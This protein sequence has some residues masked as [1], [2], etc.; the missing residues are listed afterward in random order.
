MILFCVG[1]DM[2]ITTLA[3]CM[4][5]GEILRAFADDL[6]ILLR[7]LLRCRHIL[8]M[9]DILAVFTRCFL[10][11][12]KC[13]WVRAKSKKVPDEDMK[14]WLLWAKANF[15][16]SFRM[17]E[18]EN[19]LGF[20]IGVCVSSEHI[21]NPVMRGCLAT[22][23]KWKGS[24]SVREKLLIVM[25]YVLS[26]PA[27]L[28]QLADPPTGFDGTLKVACVCFIFGI[29][30]VK[31]DT[32]TC[33]R[34][35]G[36]GFSLPNLQARRLAMRAR[37][38]LSLPA[39]YPAYGV[40]TNSREVNYSSAWSIPVAKVFHSAYTEVTKRL[41][42]T[43]ATLKA[44][45]MAK[46]TTESARENVK[47]TIQR[48]LTARLTPT[49]VSYHRYLS[50]KF[51]KIGDG[52]AILAALLRDVDEWAKH[53]SGRI[54]AAS[55]RVLLNAFFTQGRFQHHGVPCKLKCGTGEDDLVH[56]VRC[57]K[58][59]WSLRDSGIMSRADLS[60]LE[61]W[62]RKD[63]A[64]C[65]YLTNV[66]G[67]CLFPCLAFC[68]YQLHNTLRYHSISGL[69]IAR[70]FQGVIES[71]TQGEK[72]KVLL[73]K[74]QR[75]AF[76]YVPRDGCADT[77]RLD[78]DGEERAVDM[79]INNIEFDD[80][81]QSS[82]PPRPGL[83]NGVEAGMTPPR[84]NGIPANE[85]ESQM[86]NLA[87][88]GGLHM[89]VGCS[90]DL[91]T[92]VDRI[93][94][95]E[96]P[97]NGEDSTSGR[98]ADS[99]PND[100]GLVGYGDESLK[101]PFA[102]R[103]HGVYSDTSDGGEPGSAQSGSGADVSL[104]APLCGGVPTSGNK[105]LSWS[106]KP[107]FWRSLVSCPTG[108]ANASDPRTGYASAG[109]TCPSVFEQSKG[110]SNEHEHRLLGPAF[111]RNDYASNN[112]N[113]DTNNKYMCFAAG[114][115]PSPSTL[116][117][118][119]LSPCCEE[120]NRTTLLQTP[121]NGIGNDHDVP[122]TSPSVVYWY[123]DAAN[124]LRL[125]PGLGG[126]PNPSS[127]NNWG[128]EAAAQRSLAA[129]PATFDEA[130]N[131]EGGLDAARNSAGEVAYYALDTPRRKTEAH[132]AAEECCIHTPEVRRVDT[133]AEEWTRGNEPTGADWRGVYMPDGALSA[134]AA[135]LFQREHG[136]KIQR[137]E[138]EDNSGIYENEDPEVW[139]GGG[140]SSPPS[141]APRVAGLPARIKLAPLPSA[142][143]WGHRSSRWSDHTWRP[144]G[145]DG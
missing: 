133:S 48:T 85:L 5:E 35:M 66:R 55:W 78:G 39:R 51:N 104:W 75:V 137:E 67:V 143:L 16:Q 52:E 72:S 69:N 90:P 142:D 49:F 89:F 7:S 64:A 28:E 62:C 36:F 4:R 68:L 139:Y 95:F 93:S 71:L 124:T 21:F 1:F 65:A 107:T 8:G 27:Y 108:G 105:T 80:E 98:N 92:L 19:H 97:V 115:L 91:M 119:T 102:D 63:L 136:S 114:L 100:S 38:L 82:D 14:G 99:A 134:D 46:A 42:I 32:L 128:I 61:A 53:L 73:P 87:P 76:P 101:W 31:F 140:A 144:P 57:P 121:N 44:Q 83:G 30:A 88:E 116:A 10:N 123:R 106:D 56:L 113:N 18:C 118:S 145:P 20:P 47:R 25:T 17:S 126:E 127:T 77:R 110:G 60:L 84:D 11:K 12:T 109:S 131:E 13:A 37:V 9:F 50:G 120:M 112:D 141:G 3:D 33:G 103:G 86:V 34:A 70:S 125:G 79:G 94:A 58:L 81:M 22:L 6:A 23:R 129:Y 122:G 41:N 132:L 54:C 74:K 15:W 24:Y 26:R 138:M 130:P 96:V 111:S 45:L 43:P 2:V 29:N 135:C 59:L 40:M 117:P